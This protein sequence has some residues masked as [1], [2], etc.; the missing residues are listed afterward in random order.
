M[1][2][3]ILLV[4][5]TYIKIVGKEPDYTL[6]IIKSQNVLINQIAKCRTHEQLEVITDFMYVTFAKYPSNQTEAT[7]CILRSHIAWKR[8][9]MDRDKQL[10]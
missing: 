7:L 9:D 5:D 3:L 2:R 10:F 4:M 1:K 8:I 6:E